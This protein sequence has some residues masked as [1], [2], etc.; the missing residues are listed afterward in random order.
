MHVHTSFI[1]LFG[2]RL[3]T[4]IALVKEAY[5]P[6]EVRNACPPSEPYSDNSDP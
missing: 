4:L 3:W 5:L 6:L 2:C 1:R